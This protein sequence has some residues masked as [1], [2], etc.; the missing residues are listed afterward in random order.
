MSNKPFDI[1]TSIYLDG[2]RLTSALIVLVAH[3]FKVL[4][5]DLLL[6]LSFLPHLAHGAVVIFF[7]LSGYVIAYSTDI[8]K[9]TVK[10][11]SIARLS[12]LYSILFPAIVITVLCSFA[13]EMINPQIFATFSRGQDYI[14]IVLSLF[15]LNELWFFSAAPPING[16]LWSLGYEFWYYVLFGAFLFKKPGLKGWLVVFLVSLIAGPKILL[17]MVIW[18]LGAIAY[19][20]PR[21]EIADKT[22]WVF[23]LFF[24]A[25]GV[26]V[27]I[28]IPGLPYAEIEKPLVWASQFVT[29][30]IAGFLIALSVWFLPLSNNSVKPTDKI[31]SF[32]K[33]F[34]TFADMTF[35]IYVLHFPLLVITKCILSDLVSENTQLVLGGVVTFVL[36]VL[37][38][39]FFESKKNWWTQFFTILFNK[40]R[41]VSI[42]QK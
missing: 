14:R 16:P 29:D 28:A 41:L 19:R 31:M 34:R 15:Y 32:Q 25:I 39:L 12:R 6:K 36:C 10:E 42:L 37:L 2:L 40:S 18:I 21:L 7:V 1:S 35:P 24:L 11:Y 9:R 38:G 30:Y 27:I 8:K 13:A 17:M 22:S 33:K 3:A 20:L 26:T 5:P 23:V 4:N